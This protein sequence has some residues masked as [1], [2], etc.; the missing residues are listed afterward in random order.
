MH[1]QNYFQNM[2]QN[3]KHHENI[4]VFIKWKHR[5][6]LSLVLQM[7]NSPIPAT[8]TQNHKW[9]PNTCK[10]LLR[11]FSLKMLYITKIS[12]YV[13]I[14]LWHTLTSFTVQATH[15]LNANSGSHD[16]LSMLYLWNFMSGGCYIYLTLVST[17]LF[18]VKL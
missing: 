4:N 6:L 10:L 15:K 16:N 14:M 7:E 12:D 1:W 3:K 17:P 18:H 8:H 5:T 11:A 13:T 9:F 2:P